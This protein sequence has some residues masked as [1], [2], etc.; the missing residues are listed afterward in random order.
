MY[1]C[2]CIYIHEGYLFQL[3][4]K[5]FKMCSF[6]MINYSDFQKNMLIQFIALYYHEI[7]INWK[8]VSV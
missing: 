3:L 2:I 7:T 8:R 6:I 1:F 5:S 4:P